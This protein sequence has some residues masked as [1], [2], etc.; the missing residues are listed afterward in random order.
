[1]RLTLKEI[2]V[3]GT[4]VLLSSSEDRMA[5]S[6]QVAVALPSGSVCFGDT[7]RA[8]DGTLILVKAYSDPVPKTLRGYT[9][10]VCNGGTPP[11]GLSTNMDAWRLGSG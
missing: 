5:I 8:P 9:L 11:L 4:L 1:M 10:Q 3:G 2:E 6:N 7:W